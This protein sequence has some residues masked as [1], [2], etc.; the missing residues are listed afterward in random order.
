MQ[1]PAIQFIVIAVLAALFLWALS[2][3]PADATIVRFIRV[4]V[5]IVLA[6]MLLNLIL[7]LLFGGGISSFLHIT[8]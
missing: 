8:R 2:N 5:I 3:F 1:S 7:V 4:A 6:I